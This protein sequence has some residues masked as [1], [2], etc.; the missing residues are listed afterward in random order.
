MGTFLD[1]FRA[2]LKQDKGIKQS[3]KWSYQVDI[4]AR[5]Q[6]R[7]CVKSLEEQ[8]HSVSS[9]RILQ[10]LWIAEVI[11]R[12]LDKKI[13]NEQPMLEKFRYKCRNFKL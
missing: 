8:V 7:L 6:E 10:E 2:P 12:H 9:K 11:E 13:K 3:M 5:H 1:L 4:V